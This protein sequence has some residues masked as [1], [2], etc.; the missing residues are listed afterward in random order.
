MAIEPIFEKI[1]L[2]GKRQVVNEPVRVECKT[3]VATD[4]ISEVLSVSSSALALGCEEKEG[5]IKYEGRAIF[6]I[7][8][9]STD[10]E[11]RKT[12]CSSDFTG[13]IKDERIKASCKATCY[14]DALKTD[15]DLTSAS[16]G[17]SATVKVRAELLENIE[18]NA[19]AGGTNIV[20]DNAEISF[21]K[22]YGVK[23][24]V[25]PI[26][27]D[28]EISCEIK[29][30]LCHRASAS[31]T[32]VQC[33]VGSVIVDGQIYL[34]VIALQNT[35]KS[36]I[37][38]EV[39]VIPF[40]N[41]MEYEEAMPNV[42]ATASV[43]EKGLKTDVLVDQETGKSKVTVSLNLCFTGEVWTGEER[44]VVRD[45]FSVTDDIELIKEQAQ[46]YI[47]SE[48]EC[49]TV[50]FN[51][52]ASTNELPVGVTLF[53]V[54]NERVE[55]VS[56]EIV[57]GKVKVSGVVTA[58]G[59]F[60]DGEG[61][62]FT[63]KLETV[64]E[65]ELDCHFNGELDCIRARA[66][67]VTARLISATEVELDGELIFILRSRQTA[68][69]DCIKDIKSV[70]EKAEN[71]HAI[72][73]YIAMENEELWSLSKRLNVCPDS[74]VETNPDLTFPLTGEERIVIYRKL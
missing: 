17:V 9:L 69:I 72:S 7:C 73:V 52:R 64:F 24:S 49:L 66:E 61:K 35:E 55:V 23:E 8:Y 14:A 30:V 25:Y 67:R 74:L 26:E 1:S 57:G 34:S 53:A 71:P 51:G 54:G 37:I 29:E 5:Q 60:S 21:S 20:V 3:M 12:E 2:S 42:W 13:L 58:T 39:R 63:R 19:L 4:L 6:Y 28:F 65:K 27:E 16:L 70:G 18:I 43:V 22:S 59:Y 33:G 36:S 38:K 41:E 31:I 40:R 46:V 32:A 10:G 68:V 56:S 50:G 44:T 62:P 47:P 15:F 48:S 45:A 11:V